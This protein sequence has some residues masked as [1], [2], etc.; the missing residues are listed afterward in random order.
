MGTKQIYLKGGGE[1]YTFTFSLQLLLELNCVYKAILMLM[2][3]GGQQVIH[4]MR[5]TLN[6]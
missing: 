5:S 1:S 4:Q 2:R 6:L 3:L